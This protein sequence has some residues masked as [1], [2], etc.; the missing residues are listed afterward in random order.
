MTEFSMTW[1]E[2]ADD[3]RITVVIL[4]GS[5]DITSVEFLTT[6]FDALVAD[7]RCFVIVDMERVDFVSSPAVGALMG[8]RRRLIEKKGNLVLVGS[9]KS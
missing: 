2:C 8:C 3:S 7:N 6:G 9:R 4:A 5:I 1:Q